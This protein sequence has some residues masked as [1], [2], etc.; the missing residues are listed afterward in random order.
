MDNKESGSE[1][2]ILEAARKVFHQKGFE[3]A[4]MQE[5]T[6]EAGIN[7]SLLHYYYRNKENLFEAVFN[8]SF[9]QLSSRIFEI[10][11]SDLPLKEKIPGFLS[12]YMNFLLDH[13][14]IPWFIINSIYEKPDRIK[15]IFTNFGISPK[16]PIEKLHKQLL[17][18]YVVEIDPVNFFINILSLCIFPVIARSLIGQLFGMDEKKLKEFYNGRITKTS[19]FLLNSLQGYK[20]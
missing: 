6:D 17:E 9:S 10:F 16:E 14:Y 4:R 18:E 15:N 13:S 3:G 8:E 19:E 1:F 7:K 2:R 5:I 20:K 11:T 12:Y